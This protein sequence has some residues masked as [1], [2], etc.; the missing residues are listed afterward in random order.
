MWLRAAQWS[1]YREAARKN[2]TAVEHKGKS[3][4]G[5][6]EQASNI[7]RGTP[8]SFG[9]LRYRTIGQHLVRDAV[10]LRGREA[11]GS[12]GRGTTRRPARPRVSGVRRR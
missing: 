7:A 3:T 12:V 10:L 5:R 2:P 8:G 9:D 11:S 1:H 6:T 4:G